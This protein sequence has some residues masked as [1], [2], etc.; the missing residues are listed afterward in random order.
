ML[1]YENAFDERFKQSDKSI[2]DME[3]LFQKVNKNIKMAIRG[4]VKRNALKLPGEVMDLT[5][6]ITDPTATGTFTK[7]NMAAMQSTDM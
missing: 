6:P 2:K 7:E 4:E 3:D 1:E 5:T